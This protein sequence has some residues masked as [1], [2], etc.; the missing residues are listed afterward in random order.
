MA[1]Q[2]GN[3]ANMAAAAT[4]SQ[5]SLP[6]HSGPMVLMAARLLG[7][8]RPTT[9][10]RMPTPKSKPSSTKKPIHKMV[11]RMNQNGIMPLP[12]SVLS[13]TQY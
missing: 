1:Y 3:A 6:S 8:S 4:I 9:P 7:S 13:T 10:C 2:A 12:P 5:T 11:I